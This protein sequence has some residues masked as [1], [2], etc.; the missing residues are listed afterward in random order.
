MALKKRDRDGARTD[1]PDAIRAAMADTRAALTHKLETLRDRVLGPG[2]PA[3]NQGESV[4]AKKKTAGAAKK[5]GKA[6]AKRGTAK[7]T[8]VSAGRKTAGKKAAATRAAGTRKAG[9]ASKGG[10][11]KKTTRKK[12]STAAKI[13][14]KAK[15]VLGD[16]LVGAAA[17]AVKGAAGV[18]SGQTQE[19]AHAAD[20]ATPATSTTGG[21]TTGGTTYG[22][23]G[24][25]TTTGGGIW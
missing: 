3:P 14:D 23:T 7:K 11:A 19:A 5:G 13:M 15:G 6:K 4:M 8:A 2:E 25:G 24:G 21:T 10:T 22:S 20:K 17:G 16:V 12:K 18:V 9:M 1:D